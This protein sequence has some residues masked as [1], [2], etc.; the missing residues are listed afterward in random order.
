MILIEQIVRRTHPYLQ[1]KV[2]YPHSLTK[3]YKFIWNHPKILSP[4]I[5]SLEYVCRSKENEIRYDIKKL[6]NDEKNRY[7]STHL[8]KLERVLSGIENPCSSL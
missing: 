1:S 5:P 3:Q 7:Q 4:P 8:L 6:V 2:Q